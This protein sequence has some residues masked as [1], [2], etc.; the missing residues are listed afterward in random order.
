MLNQVRIFARAVGRDADLIELVIDVAQLIPRKP[1]PVSS[2]SMLTRLA[3]GTRC[4][5]PP[6]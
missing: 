2:T 1:T 3:V 4:V 5:R 6:T